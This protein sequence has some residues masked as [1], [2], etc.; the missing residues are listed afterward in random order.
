MSYKLDEIKGLEAA[1][2]E[3][4][5]AQGVGNSEVLLERA[6][7]PRDRKELAE[8]TGLTGEQIL[9]WANRADLMR[10]RG[11]GRQYSDLLEASGVDTVPELAQRNS[12]NLAARMAEVNAANS[13]VR[14]LPTES[15]V[16]DWVGQAKE[17]GRKIEY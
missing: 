12:A 2:A 15:Q 3:A 13:L 14:V 7:T 4:L 16:A 5:Q 17:L 6:R 10:V 8:A 1:H 9:A 11:V